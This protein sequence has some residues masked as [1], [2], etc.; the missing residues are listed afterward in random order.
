[1]DLLGLIFGDAD[2]GEL[3]VESA[4]RGRQEIDQV[5]CHQAASPA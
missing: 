1:M 4:Q 2:V 3:R 5:A